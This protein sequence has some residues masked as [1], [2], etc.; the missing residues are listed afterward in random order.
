M[1]R[2][3]DGMFQALW[4]ATTSRGG[5]GDRGAVAVEFALIVFPMLL[6]LSVIFGG[7]V[8]M[9]QYMQLNFVVENAA[10]LQAAGG[11]GMAYATTQLKPP[12]SFTFSSSTACGAGVSAAQ[13]TG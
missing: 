5:L 13:V 10:T 2:G 9:I 7:G 8:G 4:R 6:L 3:H 1:K 11:N 12:T